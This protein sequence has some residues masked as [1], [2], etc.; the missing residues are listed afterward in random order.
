MFDPVRRDELVLHL[1][2]KTAALKLDILPTAVSEFVD[3]D[4]AVIICAPRPGLLAGKLAM[5]G[6]MDYTPIGLLIID[7]E[8]VSLGIACKQREEVWH[9]TKPADINALFDRKLEHRPER[10]RIRF[11]HRIVEA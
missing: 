6:D 7:P 8:I 10:V 3:P 1:S 11:A 9:L 2:F 5:V 4:V